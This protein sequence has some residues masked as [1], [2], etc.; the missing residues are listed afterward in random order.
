MSTV[1]LSAL[2]PPEVLESLDFEDVYQ[3]E[4][5]VFRAY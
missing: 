2:P 3:E 5:A 1:D 4:L